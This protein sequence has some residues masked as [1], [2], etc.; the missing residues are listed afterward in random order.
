MKFAEKYLIIVSSLVLAIFSGFGFYLIRGQ[1]A[2]K[3]LVVSGHNHTLSFAYGGIL[4][5][6]ILANLNISEEMKTWL[7]YWMSLTFLG[8]IALIYAGLTGNTSILQYTDIIFQGSFVV[9]WILLAYFVGI[10]KQK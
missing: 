10:S 9:L 6:L 7:A 8:P 1:P 5:A 2:I 4:F 3:D